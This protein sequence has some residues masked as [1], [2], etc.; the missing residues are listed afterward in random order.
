MVVSPSYFSLLDIER[1]CLL[2]LIFLV[3]NACFPGKSS[4]PG[5]HPNEKSATDGEV[6]DASVLEY[7]N[8]TSG[9]GEEFFHEI[10]EK[11][12]NET[13]RGIP[14]LATEPT[15]YIMDPENWTEKRGVFKVA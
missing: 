14:T 2:F 10:R 5:D 15:M 1:I 11:L 4:E 12:K 3:N 9:S 7:N 13:D 6:E 8:F